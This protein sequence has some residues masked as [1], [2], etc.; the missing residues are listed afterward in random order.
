MFEPGLVSVISPCYNVASYLPFFFKSV[1]AQTYRKLEIILVNDGSTDDTDNVIRLWL[2]KLESAGYLVRYIVKENGGQSSAINEALSHFTGE[3]LTW[4][5]PDDFLYPD[6]IKK[7]V[8]FL[9]K[10]TECGIV[11]SAA[12]VYYENDRTKVIG[13]LKANKTITNQK[14]FFKDLVLGRT[15][16]APVCY[17]VRSSYFLLTNPSRTIYIRKDA[18]QNWQMLLPIAAKYE[19]GY[20]AESL[21]GYLLRENSHSHVNIT[22]DSKLK[23]LDMSLDVLRNTLKTIDPGNFT[24]INELDIHFSVKRYHLGLEFRDRKF[25]LNELQVLEKKRKLTAIEKLIK[26]LCGNWLLF[27]VV[28]LAFLLKRLTRKIISKVVCQ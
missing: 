3:F 1:L 2:P 15:Y 21:C 22:L 14:I 12:D 7:R 25:T 16:F 24:L 8:E 23:Y 10:K 27:H 5:D 19:C 11:R 18:G 17:M 20:L 26:P 13:F 6:S 28:I 4:P 9:C